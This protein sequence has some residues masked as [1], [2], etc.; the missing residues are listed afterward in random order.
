LHKGDQRAWSR[1]F[2]P[3]A[4]PYDDGK[5]RALKSLPADALVTTIHLHRSCREQRLD[6]LVPS[7]R[8]I[9]VT[10]DLLQV[11]DLSAGKI[12]RL[13]IGQAA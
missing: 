2:E 13:E 12:N 1:F 9:G 5:P 7:T 4:Q 6:R 10:F 8:T 3:D 11:S